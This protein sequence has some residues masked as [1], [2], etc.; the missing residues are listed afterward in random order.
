MFN[1]KKVIYVYMC[2]GTVVNI[3][4]NASA[5]CRAPAQKRAGNAAA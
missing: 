1:F 3:R 5:I 4:E 2:L